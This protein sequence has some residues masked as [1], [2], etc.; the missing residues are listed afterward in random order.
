VELERQE[1]ASEAETITRLRVVK[2][3]PVVE[4][5]DKARTLRLLLEMD[6]PIA[7][8]V[9]QLHTLRVATETLLERV[10][11]LTTVGVAEADLW[12]QPLDKTVVPVL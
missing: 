11:E 8:P 10:A 12:T 7:L 1:K 4:Q 3:R 6:K 2:V 9:L 5:Q